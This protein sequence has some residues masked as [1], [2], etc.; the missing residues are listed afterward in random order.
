MSTLPET[1]GMDIFNKAFDEADPIWSMRIP[2]RQ[3]RIL[4]MHA[5]FV[6][7]EPCKFDELGNPTGCMFRFLTSRKNW[8]AP[9]AAL[10]IFIPIDL[11]HCFLEGLGGLNLFDRPI[12][13][14]WFDIKIE[15]L[16]K[17]SGKNSIDRFELIDIEQSP[18]GYNYYI[19]EGN[20]GREACLTSNCQINIFKS[21]KKHYQITFTPYDE[22]DNKW[23]PKP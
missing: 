23:N 19:L 3:P 9:Y 15:S 5:Q 16:K 2:D 7:K 17:P 6:A 20:D 12:E 18:R 10:D 11:K 22:W 8:S 14:I 13:D 1:C 4:P 21:N